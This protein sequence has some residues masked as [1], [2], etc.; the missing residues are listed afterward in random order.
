MKTHQFANANTVLGLFAAL[1]NG[2]AAAMMLG[3]SR[4]SDLQVAQ[5]LLIAAAGLVMALAGVVRIAGWISLPRALKTQAG[6]LTLLL[7]ML[8]LLGLSILFGN[9]G[10]TATS[11]MVGILTALSVYLY[12]LVTRGIPEISLASVRP[13]LLSLCVLS[14]VVDLAV[15]A[16]VGWF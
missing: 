16:R 11:W 10:G 12:F 3:D 6:G 7:C 2:G 9:A 13:G 5:A 8:N 15:F 4:A 14:G 1:T